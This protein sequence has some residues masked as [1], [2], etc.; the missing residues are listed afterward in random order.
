MLRGFIVG[1]VLP[2]LFALAVIGLSWWWTGG[3]QLGR[4]AFK[5]DAGSTG[6][7]TDQF[8]Q[9][10]AMWASHFGY[11]FAVP[12]ALALVW[13]T[14]SSR[15]RVLAVWCWASVLPMLLLVDW[16]RVG[17]PASYLLESAYSAGVL[18]IIL[19]CAIHR[20]LANR[21]LASN[22]FAG[23][24]ALAILH[25]GVASADACLGQARLAPWTGVQIMWG[26]VRPETGIKAAGWYVRTHVPSDA[27]VM[28][29]HT[30]TGM[31]GPVAEYYCGRAVLADYDLRPDM[32]EPLICEMHRDVN[33]LIVDPA[34]R[35]LADTLPGLEPVAVLRHEGRP[36][37]YVYARQEMQLAHVDSDSTALNRCFD[38]QYRSSKL[39]QP[40]VASPAFEIQFDRYLKL[41]NQLRTNR[42]G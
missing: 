31:E 16:D 27:I 5:H 25:M 18:G 41:V 35:E 1:Y 26:S 11:A 30:N 28:A 12:A 8:I 33:V 2:C 34:W 9:L 19:V 40:L 32:V 22:L 4:L 10:P 36:V 21:P 39:P 38:T 3:G 14:Y 23:T 29:L 24:V 42:N 20:H 13:A 37:R 17:Y 15:W 6:L 7:Q